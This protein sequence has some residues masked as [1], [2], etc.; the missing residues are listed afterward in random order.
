MTDPIASITGSPMRDINHFID[1]A[2][3]TGVLSV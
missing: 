2:S 3:F 1:G